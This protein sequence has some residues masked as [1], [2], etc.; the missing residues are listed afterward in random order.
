M[1]RLILE[2]SLCDINLVKIKVIKQS[3]INLDKNRVPHNQ[4]KHIYNQYHFIMNCV[5]DK[6]IFLNVVRS[7]D[8]IADVFTKTLKSIKFEAF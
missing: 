1:S 3:T 5:H 4:T 2:N 8:Q 6:K 7:L